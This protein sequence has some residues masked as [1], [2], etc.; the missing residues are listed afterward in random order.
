MHAL[1]ASALCLGIA[2]AFDAGAVL[3]EADQ[4]ALRK[5]IEIERIDAQ[6]IQLVWHHLDFSQL[7]V[8][9]IGDVVATVFS[10]MENRV[11]DMPALGASTMWL[12]GEAVSVNARS[13]IAVAATGAS[14]SKASPTLSNI[15]VEPPAPPNS[16]AANAEADNDPPS[17]PNRFYWD[18][19]VVRGKGVIQFAQAETAP[20]E[21]PTQAPVQ[22]NEGLL[23]GRSPTPTTTEI[24][25]PPI[26]PIPE[27][28]AVERSSAAPPPKPDAAV[29]RHSDS[30]KDFDIREPRELPSRAEPELWT[31]TLA[32]ADTP[33]KVASVG[34]APIT[35]DLDGMQGPDRDP[36]SGKPRSQDNPP[37]PPGKAPDDVVNPPGLGKSPDDI[38]NPPGLGKSP[39]DVVNPPGLGKSPKEIVD[40][41]GLGKSPED[42]VNPL[43]LGK[44]PSQAI[45]DLVS[46][47]PGVIQAVPE[48]STYAFMAGGLGLMGFYLRKKRAQL[49]ADKGTPP[50]D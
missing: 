11:P 46:P 23:R 45:D 49:R 21:T 4:E 36:L 27:V 33:E 8:S 18:A 12:N 15:S 20:L 19:F 14:D 2:A 3:S 17:R 37:S 40:P 39:E 5:A 31:P 28:P 16:F 22:E 41:P 30:E 9:E 7:K 38:V 26:E 24:A 42:I 44:S 32:V 25:S 13:A 47:P 48:P 43:G 34:R 35:V 1:R 6:S 29:A 50:Q 10:E